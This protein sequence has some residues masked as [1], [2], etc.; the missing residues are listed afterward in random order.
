MF[1]G[2]RLELEM[3]VPKMSFE[4][5]SKPIVSGTDRDLLLIHRMLT[6]DIVRFSVNE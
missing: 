3:R 6:Y 1:T 5:S 4:A 2:G